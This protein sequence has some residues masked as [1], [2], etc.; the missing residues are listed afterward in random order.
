[1]TSFQ[2]RYDYWTPPVGRDPLPDGLIDELGPFLEAMF[3]GPTEVQRWLARALGR[4]ERPF[5]VHDPDLEDALASENRSTL[6]SLPWGRVLGLTEP[7]LSRDGPWAER[8]NT[9]FSR[10]DVP[11]RVVNG[12]KIEAVANCRAWGLPTTPAPAPLSQRSRMPASQSTQYAA[13]PALTE[14]L[15]NHG[16]TSSRAGSTQQNSSRDTTQSTNLGGFLLTVVGLL[17]ASWLGLLQLHDLVPFTNGLYGCD[18]LLSVVISIGVYFFLRWTWP[19]SILTFAAILVLSVSST[20]CFRNRAYAAM[21][22]VVANPATLLQRPSI[23]PSAFDVLTDQE[24]KRIASFA[25]SQGTHV[26]YVTSTSDITARQYAT[27]LADAFENGGWKIPDRSKDEARLVTVRTGNLNPNEPEVAV[28]PAGGLGAAVST[29]LRILGLHATAW[30]MSLA[31][32]AGFRTAQ[33]RPNALAIW[34]GAVRR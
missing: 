10:Y 28:Y 26:V 15:P 13:L 5:A 29:E 24:A 9:I 31:P 30:P 11:W 33:T 18:V 3:G 20:I 1:M 14:Q 27:S 34:I 17:V 16:P 12:R 25:R 19:S 7:E 2:K 6:C 21:I 22:G 23:P 4:P 32:P 8:L